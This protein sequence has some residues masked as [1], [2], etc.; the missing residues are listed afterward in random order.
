[1]TQSDHPSIRPIAFHL[2]QFHPIPENDQWWGKGF[3]E[4]TNVVKARPRLPGHY[5]PHLPADL[6][7]YDLRLPEA[8]AAQA[9]LAAEY[10]IHGFCYYHYWFHGRELLERPVNEIL[11]TGEPDFPFCFCWANE[12]WSRRWDASND[13]LLVEQRCS[14]ADDLAHIR[15]LIEFFLD[16]RYIRVDGRPLI[17]IYRASKLPE[18]SRTIDLWRREAERA[19]LKG[20][21][22]VRVESHVESG[23]PRSMGF[24]AALQFEPCWPAL[25]ALRIVRRRWWHRHKLGTGEAV[26]RNNVICEYA[27]LVQR[28]LSE[29]SPVYPR[30]PCVC[31]GWDNTPRREKGAIIF[32]NSTPA[33]YESWLSEV[34]KRQAARLSALPERNGLTPME[35][36]IFI[37]AWNE[38]AEGNHLEPDQKWGRAYLEATRR[39]LRTHVAAG[40]SQLTPSLR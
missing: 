25:G 14:P 35:S 28:A 10:G 2:P 23:D 22:L 1:M 37:N 5:Q 4:W 13:E 27:D 32:L 18:P 21:Y 6:G 11:S 34:V 38:W 40:P 26:Y 8:R 12:N 39:A 7:F 19:G 15:R 20:L 30:I 3:T 31:P 36:L 9:K 24:D 16:P 29:P 17:A 33:L